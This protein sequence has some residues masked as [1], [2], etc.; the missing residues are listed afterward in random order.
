[1][2]FTTLVSLGATIASTA[3]K[4]S[5][6][7]EQSK[8]LG[9]MATQQQES[10]EEQKEL[11]IDNALANNTRA[12]KN[13][14]N[15]LADARLD[16]AKSNLAPTGSAYMRE[17]SMATRL[18]DEITHTTDRSLQDANLVYEQALFDAQ[19]TRLKSQAAKTDA[20]SSLFEGLGSMANTINNS[21]KVK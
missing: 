3:I 15:E 17:V 2:G 18:Q 16:A 21:S 13:M 12:K 5:S 11:L 4:T 10:G 7:M 1:M 20:W 6:S 19:S 9:N 14:Q 8:A